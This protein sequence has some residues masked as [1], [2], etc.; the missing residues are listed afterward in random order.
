M[1]SE[2]TSAIVLRVTEFSETSCVV[3]LLTEDFGKVTALAKGARRPKSPF[4]AA[5]D[6]LAVCR[7]VMLHK[8]HAMSLLTEARLEHRFRAG[9]RDLDRLYVGY[10]MVELLKSLTD[11]GDPQPELFVFA[12]DALLRLDS[13]RQ[14][15]IPNLREFVLK[16]ELGLLDLIGQLPMLTR[17]VSCGREKTMLSKVNFGLNAGGVLC[18][19]CRRGQS[20]IVS[21]G[22]KAFGYLLE[23]A[24]AQVGSA[25][26]NSDN[27]NAPDRIHE[28]RVRARS[29]NAGRPETEKTSE[30]DES[31]LRMPADSMFATTDGQPVGGDGAVA[32]CRRLMTQYMTHLLGQ[33]PRL[34]KFLQRL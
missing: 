12:R 2:K 18:Q 23:L 25:S 11:E 10:Y 29:W 3:V 8:T 6:L 24:G 28:Q 7:V 14:G 16:F 17:C 5:L 9:E 26:N 1:P 13:G 22:P 21:V 4:E 32:E 27:W 15:D 31:P 30:L 34:H 19:S 20:G 33:P